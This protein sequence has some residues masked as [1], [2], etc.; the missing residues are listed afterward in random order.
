MQRFPFASL[1][2]RLLLLI[3]LAVVPVIGLTIYTNIEL[4]RLAA[5]DAKAEALRLVRLAASDQQDTI[6]DT[7]QFLFALA[8]LPDIRSANSVACSAFLARLFNQYPQ[9]ALLG[10]LGS[11]GDLMCSALPIDGPINLAHRD[12]FQQ[13]LQTRDFAR[14]RR[15]PLLTATGPSWCVTRTQASGLDS[16]YRRHP[17]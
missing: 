3:L 14:G 1:R 13:C 6:K 7:R 4:R 16:P 12:Y 10:V 17:S 11:D 2:A 15:S 5:A 8:Q 9:Y